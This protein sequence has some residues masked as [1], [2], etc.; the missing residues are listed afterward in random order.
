M[1]GLRCCPGP[2]STRKPPPSLAS[3]QN[4]MPRLRPAPDLLEIAEGEATGIPRPRTR[5]VFTA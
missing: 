5:T 3:R 2:V 1:S 4:N